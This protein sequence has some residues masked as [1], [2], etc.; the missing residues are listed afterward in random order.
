MKTNKDFL[1]SLLPEDAHALLTSKGVDLVERLGNDTIRDVLSDVFSG[2]NL[3]ES[4]EFLTRKRVSALNLG[5]IMLFIRGAQK[6][7]GFIKNLPTISTKILQT[8]GVSRGE[9]WLSQWMLGLTDKAFQNVLRDSSDALD[10]YRERY[11]TIINDLLTTTEQSHGKLN[12]Y[13]QVGK[14]ETPID[15]RFLAALLNA[16]GSQTLAIRGSEKSAYGKLF[17]KLILGSLLSILGFKF[18][19]EKKAQ[20]YTF[21]LSSRSQKRESDATLIY[22]KGQAIR[23][24][25]GFIGRGNSEITLDKV[26]RFERHADFGA[27]KYFVGTIIIV[28]RVGKG[29]KVEDLANQIDGE[30]VQ[31]SASYW[32]R[33]VALIMKKTLKDFDHPVI[34]IKDH[35][36]SDYI[37]KELGKVDISKFISS[38]IEIE[39]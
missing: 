34:R 1:L 29:S 8:R 9:K 28:D 20:E 6:H 39:D 32:I 15:W 35:E 13:L 5:L 2:K 7:P 4:T 27:K 21:W 10:A 24:D 12:G 18:S 37:R 38:E 36:M 25:I 22:E 19:N 31:M 26:S 14:Q 17:E 33:N 16:V 23:F 30:L 11:E 3:R